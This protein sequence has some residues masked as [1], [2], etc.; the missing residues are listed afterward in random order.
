MYTYRIEQAIKAATI[1]HKN[2]LR[3]GSIPLP[4]VSHLFAVTMI[5]SDYTDDED[6]IVAAL[7]HDTLEDTDYTEDELRSD[8]GNLVADAIL[9]ISEPTEP[10][11]SWRDGKVAYVK[12]LKKAT[13]LALLV[14]A[15]D[16]IHNMRSVV[17]EY[18][19]DHSRFMADFGKQLDDR[20]EMYQNISN[21]LNNRL[22][23]AILGE[24]NHVFEE[25][26]NFV[27]DVQKSQAKRQ[28]I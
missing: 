28:T 2:Q 5:V 4:Y 23:N 1:L 6:T 19:E 14:A 7:L 22:D 9:T 10:G 17:E 3:K 26:K 11:L 27:Y 16:K 13:K 18:F 15:A 12:Q 25:Y 24:F 8:F 20:I 21:V